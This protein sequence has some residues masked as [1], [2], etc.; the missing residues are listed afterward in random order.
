MLST[1][2]HGS[3]YFGSDGMMVQAITLAAVQFA[4]IFDVTDLS[5][6]NGM[7]SQ[8]L[9]KNGDCIPHRPRPLS[10]APLCRR[11]ALSREGVDCKSVRDRAYG[12]LQRVLSHLCRT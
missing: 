8:M 12:V 9:P 5:P 3:N 7:G 11:A 1:A 6:I 4:G 2:I 10:S